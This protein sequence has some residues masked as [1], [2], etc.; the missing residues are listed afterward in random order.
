MQGRAGYLKW[1][2]ELKGSHAA[3]VIGLMQQAGYDDAAC[4][5][6]KRWILKK[7]IKTDP[8]NQVRMQHTVAAY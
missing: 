6:V 4:E 5:K 2:E 3:T 1:R 8:E 7:D